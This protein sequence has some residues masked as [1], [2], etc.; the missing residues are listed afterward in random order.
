MFQR[1]EL[2]QL[3]KQKALLILQSEANR[4]KLGEDWRHL[5]SPDFWVNEAHGIVRRHPAIAT[6]LAAAGGILAVRFLRK[7]GGIGGA[8]GGLG[9]LA[10]VAMTVWRLFRRPKD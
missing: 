5:S 8:L 7:P 10:S 1:E 2:D 4:Q 9:K 6:G 3:Q